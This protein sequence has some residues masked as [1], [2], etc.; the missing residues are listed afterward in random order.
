MGLKRTDT[1]VRLYFHPKLDVAKAQL[2]LAN[3]QLETAGQ[4]QNPT[5]NGNIAR[6]NQKNG[7]IRPWAYGLNVEI[8]I[9]T[10]NKREIRIEEAQHLAEAARIDVAD[11][12]WQLRS[13]IAKDLLVAPVVG[14]V[15]DRQAACG[16]GGVPVVGR[17]RVARRGTTR[18]RARP[19]GCGSVVV[20]LGSGS[21]V[22]CSRTIP[23]RGPCRLPAWCRWVDA[24]W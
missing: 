1:C 10:A 8:P 13:Q 21:P 3:A 4:K 9:E 22:G 11:V 24:E 5:L 2:A 20:L 12:A 23:A 6:S 16:S 17:R 15:V 7:D 19:R 14:G 18:V